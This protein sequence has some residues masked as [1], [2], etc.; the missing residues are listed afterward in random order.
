MLKFLRV[1][2]LVVSLF[3]F[4]LYRLFQIPSCI[5]QY[6]TATE[7]ARYAYRG[8]LRETKTCSTRVLSRKTLFLR[9]LLDAD[10]DTSTAVVAV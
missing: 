1:C 9:G 4:F 7:F 8:S 6:P 5:S 10:V 2:S 3:F